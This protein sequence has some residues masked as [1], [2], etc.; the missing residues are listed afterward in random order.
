LIRPG[1][2]DSTSNQM[3]TVY[4]NVH[5]GGEFIGLKKFG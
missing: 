3:L 2:F 1:L 4:A 5:A